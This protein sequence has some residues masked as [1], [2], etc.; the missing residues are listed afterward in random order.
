MLDL[1]ESCTVAVCWSNLRVRSPFRVFGPMMS[2]S[3]INSVQKMEIRAKTPYNKAQG[4]A[5]RSCCPSMANAEMKIL[6]AEKLHHP[7]IPTVRRTPTIPCNENITAKLESRIMGR[8]QYP[9]TLAT[10]PNETPVILIK[11]NK[12]NIPRHPIALIPY[13]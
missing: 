4:Y 1:H 13:T 8:R 9:R 11:F 2:T 10:Q 7:M 5:I 6:E 3:Q 12:Q